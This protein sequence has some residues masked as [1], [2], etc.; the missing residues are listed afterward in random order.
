MLTERQ[1]TTGMIKQLQQRLRAIDAVKSAQVL[2]NNV[3]AAKR[4]LAM[5][6]AL[7]VEG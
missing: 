7:K 1:F 5:R 2:F 4:E 6:R 3:E